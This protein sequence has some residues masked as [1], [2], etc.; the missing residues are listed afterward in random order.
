MGLNLIINGLIAAYYIVYQSYDSDEEENPM[1]TPIESILKV[2]IMS[3]G[4]FGDIW[5]S[6]DDT[7][8]SFI[9]KIHC[10]IFLAL[11]YILLVNLLIAMMGDTYTKIAGKEATELFM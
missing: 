11:V 4:S 5:E 8:H 9:G 6:L 10:F 7:D 1:P 2:F 3:L